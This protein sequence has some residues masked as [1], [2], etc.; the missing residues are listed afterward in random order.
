MVD[1]ISLS[2]QLPSMSFS[3]GILSIFER[4]HSLSRSK[5]ATVDWIV[6][7]RV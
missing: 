2:R 7:R 3:I 5:E 1:Q 6:C 4:Q